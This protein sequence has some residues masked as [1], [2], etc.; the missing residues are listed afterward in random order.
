MFGSGSGGGGF[1]IGVGTL[2][3]IG[4]VVFVLFALSLW[5]ALRK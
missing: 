4:I 2:A 5:M 3:V 1:V